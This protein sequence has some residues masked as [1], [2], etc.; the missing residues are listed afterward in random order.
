[1]TTFLNIVLVPKT[2]LTRWGMDSTRP[3]KVCCGIDKYPLSTVSCHSH[4]R[5]LFPWKGVHGLQQCLGSWY[6]SKY[7]T[8]CDAMCI[9]TPFHWIGPHG[10]A[11]TPHMHQWALA[12]RDPVAGHH[13]PFLE[14]LLIDTDHCRPTRAAV[15]EMLWP[16]HLAI[17]IWP[18]SNILKSLRLPIFPASNTSNLRTKCSLAAQYIPLTNRCC[19]EE[20][21][22]VYLLH[23]SVVKM[24]CLIG[25]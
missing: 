18:L 12:T 17:T 22:S 21:I 8:N 10:P 14:P 9:L 23:L 11:F 7:T 19:D 3:L 15:L 20:I 4:Q 1:M 2:A 16:S 24:L 25:L 13:C 5:I 6:M